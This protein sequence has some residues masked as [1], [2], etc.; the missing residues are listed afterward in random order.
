M[1]N[2]KFLKLITCAI[3]SICVYDNNI[4]CSMENNNQKNLRNNTNNSIANE[5]QR[6]NDLILEPSAEIL[7][8]LNNE[9]YNENSS[10]EEIINYITKCADAINKANNTKEQLLDIIADMRDNGC[11][12][13][14]DL[15][16]VYNRDKNAPHSM[17]QE[18]VG[19]SLENL[20]FYK[21]SAAKLKK[22]IDTLK[23]IIKNRDNI[24]QELLDKMNQ[25]IASIK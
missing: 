22:K 9:Q 24:N 11:D 7:N 19:T 12:H 15:L 18:A 25:A 2:K 21:K 8:N 20:W 6:Y 1:I 14:T 5:V 17:E 3:V 4:I 10:S 23:E 16:Q 13:Y